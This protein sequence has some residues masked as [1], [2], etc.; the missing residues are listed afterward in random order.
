VAHHDYAVLS[1]TGSDSNAQFQLFNPWGTNQPKAITW[2]QL[3]QPGYFTQDGDTIVGAAAP[4]GLPSGEPATSGPGLHLADIFSPNLGGARYSAPQFQAALSSDS[5]AAY[6]GAFAPHFTA[7]PAGSGGVAR[8]DLT[9]ALDGMF[10]AAG[11]E[12]RPF[13]PAGLVASLSA[14][15]KPN[16]VA[17]DALFL[18]G[19]CLAGVA[20]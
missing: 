18:M 16:S 12:G 20:D 2:A 9:A 14:R 5:L 13:D 1:V 15:A 7:S 3:T 8:Q 4:T 6:F 10:V 19:D 17:L 11:D